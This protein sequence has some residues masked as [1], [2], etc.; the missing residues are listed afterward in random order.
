MNLAH[1]HLL[2][3]HFP[4]VGFGVGL[5]IF[6]FALLG[7]N[8]ELK[9]TGFIVFVIMAL[10]A[11]AAYVSGN[12]AQ[13]VLKGR[14]GVSDAVIKAHQD[15][16][17]LAFISMEITGALAWLALWQYRQTSRTQAWTTTAVLVLSIVS[18]GLMA[19]TANLGGE[20]RHPE[21]VPE[22]ASAAS[23]RPAS[24]ETAAIVASFVID[25]PWV[26][27]GSETLHFIG[28]SLLFGVVLTVNLRMLGLIRS[29][30]FSAM[31]RLLPWGMIGLAI[32]TAT[33]MLFFVAKPEQYTYNLA[34]QWKVVFLLLAGGNLL[35]LT[36]FEDAW[37]FGEGDEPRLPVKLVAAFS[38]FLWVGVIFFGR[39]LPYIGSE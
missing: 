13:M 19:Q 18:F 32:N 34:F 5:A 15:A 23:S 11:F 1:V 24:I 27:P 36:I 26:W 16:A 8:E 29:V 30:P 9:R 7:K 37:V 22:G 4:T 17:L 33:G 35:F 10:L 3:N 21:I 31:H 25:N 6:I 14:E 2:L 28:L 20:I 39:M 38:I 12:A